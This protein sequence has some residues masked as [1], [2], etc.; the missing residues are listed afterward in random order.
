MKNNLLNLEFN[1]VKFPIIFPIIYVFI[2]YIFP[3]FETYLLFFTILFLAET[4]FGATWPFFLN[5]SN[6]KFISD[7]KVNLLVYPFLIMIF[8]LFGFIFFKNLFLLI[9]FAVNM[10]HVTRQSFGICKLYTKNNN[11]IKFQSFIIYFFNILF[12]LIGYFRF[13]VPIINSDY[14]IYLNI[15][16]LL[17]VILSLFFYYNKFNKENIFIFLTGIIIFY[18]ICF[19]SNPVHSIIMGVTM[20]Y[21]QYLYLTHKVHEGRKK[22]KLSTNSY[23]YFFVIFSYA[24]VMALLSLAGKSSNEIFSMLIIIPITGQMLH[25]YLDS[26]LWKFSNHH[27]R[28]NVLYYLK[29]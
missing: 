11:E 12:F 2:L 9:F 15:I 25:F 3:Q 17:L 27:N 14:L 21:T 8:S 4:H 26:Q 18:P 13:Y 10:F 20:H 5:K 7:N 23:Y 1:L 28:E 19:V 16:I 29:D 22:N 6:S 24:F